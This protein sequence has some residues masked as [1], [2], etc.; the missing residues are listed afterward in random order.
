MRIR[1]LPT[2]KLR[3]RAEEL[4][5]E[6]SRRNNTT[7]LDSSFEWSKTEEGH[8]FWRACEY[9]QWERAARLRPEYF[10]EDNTNA[11]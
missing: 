11:I 10:E 6:T 2:E 4:R 8:D 7:Y 5:S 3:L 9:E 1:D